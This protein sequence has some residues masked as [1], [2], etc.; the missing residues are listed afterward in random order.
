MIVLISTNVSESLIERTK[1]NLASDPCVSPTVSKKSVPDWVADSSSQRLFLKP[2]HDSLQLQQQE[3][4]LSLGS[5]SRE[6][7]PVDQR[8]HSHRTAP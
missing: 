3:I 1:L 5:S 6:T 2:F 7:S 4:L 8:H